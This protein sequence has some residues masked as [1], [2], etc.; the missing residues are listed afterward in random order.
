M[1]KLVRII[2]VCLLCLSFTS[3]SFAYTTVHHFVNMGRDFLN[4]ISAPF[5]AL[6]IEGPRNV[7]KMY[8]YEVKERE[9]P[10]KRDCLKFKF[11]AVI[12]AP[13][14]ET[15]ALID[16]IV[17]SVSFSGKFCKEFLSIPFSD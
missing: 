4:L 16:G 6:F 5:K 15:K 11:F 7:K 3:L 13:A 1:A 14:V 9:K 8:K 12:S 2:L 17:E 10:E